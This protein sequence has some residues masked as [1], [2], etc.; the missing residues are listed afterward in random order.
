MSDFALQ[1]ARRFRPAHLVIVLTAVIASFAVLDLV[2]RHAL[3]SL[4]AFRLEDSD[5]AARNSL[6]AVVIGLF[7]MSACALTVAAG[8]MRPPAGAI[9]WTLGAVV[10]AFFAVE[11]TLGVHTWVEQ[12]ADVSWNV[13]YL[14]FL[15]I[16]AIVWFETARAMGDDRRA[17]A[18]FALGG[19]GWLVAG[20]FDAARTGRTSAMP[21]GELLEMASAAAMLLGM[22]TYARSLS[23][24]QS[25]LASLREANMAIVSSAVSRLDPRTLLLGFAGCLV[26]LGVL[27]AIVYPG[28]GTLRVFD[29]N[30]E[31]TFPA[32]FSGLLLFGAAAMALMN[33]VVR[34]PNP[35]DRRWWLVLAAVFA[36][37]GLDEIAALHEAVQD[38][39]HLWG[40]A[41]LAPVVFAGIAAWFIAL[42]RLSASS[43]GA[44]RLFVL[45]AAAWIASQGIDLVLNE[46]WGWTIIPEELGE[47]AGSALFG[48]ALLVAVRELVA[49]R[50]R[51]A[52]ATS[53][54]VAP[55]DALQP[56]R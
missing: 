17:Q 32:T 39:V 27:G 31:Q 42:K 1:L 4:V 19:A 9:W 52:R 8:R 38:R 54:A 50:S 3:D 48:L 23:L 53:P 47:M 45:G 6:P 16:A 26:V 44:A 49:V 55:L 29:L 2:Y 11:E 51:G 22:C 36:F 14:P 30:K 25:P 28:G 35:S 5:P 24:A 15:A 21:G 43:P 34:S 46:H 18:I 12:H 20:L 10:L 33:G 56:A 41:T 13:A 7:L 37:L 40:Q